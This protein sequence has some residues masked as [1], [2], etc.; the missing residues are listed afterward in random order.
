MTVKYIGFS[1][2]QCGRFQ[3]NQ[4]LYLQ[5]VCEKIGLPHSNRLN[6]HVTPPLSTASSIFPSGLPRHSSSFTR[7]RTYTQHTHPPTTALLNCHCTVL[8]ALRRCSSSLESDPSSPATFHVCN[9]TAQNGTNWSTTGLSDYFPVW[10][11]I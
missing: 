9:V 1:I 2:K 11:F 4:Q 6:C 8:T 5:N 7:F 3:N 10:R